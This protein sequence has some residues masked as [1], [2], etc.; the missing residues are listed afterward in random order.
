LQEALG[1]GQSPMSLFPEQ[2]PD[3]VIITIPDPSD[4]IMGTFRLQS[5][6]SK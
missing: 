3:P 6:P 5:N 4:G 1:K 2:L